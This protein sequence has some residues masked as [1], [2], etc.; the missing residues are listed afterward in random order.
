ML[1]SASARGKLLV[2]V[3]FRLSYSCRVGLHPIPSHLFGN[4]PEPGAMASSSLFP[5]IS[6]YSVLPHVR[7]SPF[8]QVEITFSLFLSTRRRFLY[9][10]YVFFSTSTRPGAF[11]QFNRAGSNI[12]LL[13]REQC[14]ELLRF[15]VEFLVPWKIQ[16]W[17]WINYVEVWL[18]QM[19]V[20]GKHPRGGYRCAVCDSKSIAFLTWLG[21]AALS[22][23]PMT[24]SWHPD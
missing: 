2:Q 17:F 13:S 10:M 14:Y 20:A 12:T 19:V 3:K 23:P 1:C 18:R 22:V 24:N 6:F 4:Q 16:E 7:N 9:S 21:V 8:D 15:T 11:L 5:L